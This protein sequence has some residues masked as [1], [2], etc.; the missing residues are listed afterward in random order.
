MAATHFTGPVVSEY[1]FAPGASSVLDVTGATTLTTADNGKLISLNA[2]A[3]AAITLPAV[4]NTGFKCKFVVSTVFA[5]TDWVISSVEGDNIEGALNI[6]DTL[7]TVDAADSFTFEL[8]AENIGDFVEII[9]DGTSW[10]V[11][12]VGLN[13]SSLSST[14]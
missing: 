6:A 9:S 5:T 14:G 8:G 7:T 2:A 10:L 1:G 3:G 13:A 11:N 4:T 12:G